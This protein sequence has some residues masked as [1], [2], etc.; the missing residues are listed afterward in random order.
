M[1]F[2]WISAHAAKTVHHL[3][4]CFISFT[5]PCIIGNLTGNLY[6]VVSAQ[7]LKLDIVIA[8]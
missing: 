6:F 5:F 7:I 2:A 1:G 8:F 4:I 3:P